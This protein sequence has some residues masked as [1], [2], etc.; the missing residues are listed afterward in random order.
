MKKL[1]FVLILIGLASLQLWAQVP[2]VPR[3]PA[4]WEEIRGVVMEVE[5]MRSHPSVSFDEAVEPYV[6]VARACI[7][8]NIALY[9]I[10]SDTIDDLG[11]LKPFDLDTVFSNRGIVSPLIHI[12]DVDNLESFTAAPWSRDHGMFAIYENE[13][14]ARKLADF[15][16]VASTQTLIATTLGIPSLNIPTSTN[17]GQAYYDG[18][19]WLCDGHHT[20]NIANI[21]HGI[22]PGLQQPAK[23]DFTNYMGIQKTL[24]VTGVGI[25]VD[26]WLKMLNEETFVVS[27][28]PQANYNPID[29]KTDHQ[30]DIDASVALIK[31]QLTS[32]FGRSFTFHQIRNAPTYNNTSLNTTYLTADAS[33]TNSLIL[34]KTVLVPQYGVQPFDQDALDAYAALMP[35]YTIT[36]ILCPQYAQAG[37]AIHCITHEIYADEPIYIKHAWIKDTVVIAPQFAINATIKSQSGIATARLYW[38]TEGSASWTTVPML[39]SG[40]E[41]TAQIPGQPAGTT[42]VYYISASNNLGKSISK[43]FVAPA[44]VYKF[45]IKQG[46][47][48]AETSREVAEKITLYPNPASGKVTVTI[49]GLDRHTP[50]LIECYDISGHKVRAR[51]L[52]ERDFDI[53]GLA[54]GTYILRIVFKDGTL[55]GTVPLTVQ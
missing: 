41:Y 54:S 5:P 19:N 31:Q 18:G 36:G 2:T 21:S 55:C 24:N 29:N 25:H 43:P 1:L 9:C 42:I 50:I 3:A 26:Y 17:T 52:A 13:T 14:G 23:P 30:V 16:I 51:N 53:S 20:F 47:G 8:E 11:T 44:G 33:Y 22:Q 15:D 6:K 45:Y 46:L 48:I 34:N 7:N 4:E 12:L 27:Y 37:G 28:I 40:A 39:A 38:K 10:T 32:A 35:G 49:P